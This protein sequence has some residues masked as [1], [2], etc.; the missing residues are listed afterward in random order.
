MKKFQAEGFPLEVKTVLGWSINTRLLRIYLPPEKYTDWN[1]DINY[2]LSNPKVSKK[3]METLI[4]RLGH[5]A[6]LMEMLRQFMNR[7]RNALQR[8]IKSRFTTLSLQEL[9]DLVLLQQFIYAASSNRI[10]LNNLAFR[11]PTHLYRSDSS[12]H[13]LGGY[14]ILTGKAW[15]FEIPPI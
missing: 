6:S 5:V 13:G 12:L 2:Y 9:E 7:L 11:N 10:S 1:N 3:N 14:S 4:G 15:R 8:S